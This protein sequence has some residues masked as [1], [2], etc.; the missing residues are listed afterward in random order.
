MNATSGIE[1]NE[2]QPWVAL[3]LTLDKIDHL[4]VHV[5]VQAQRRIDR[6]RGWI[7]LEG[8][9]RRLSGAEL[10]AVDRELHELHELL[11]GGVR[12]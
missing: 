7:P 8:N 6:L 12:R 11:F 3:E 9:D 4:G 2:L 5:S 1:D 10:L